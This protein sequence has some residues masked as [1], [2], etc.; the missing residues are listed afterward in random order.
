MPAWARTEIESPLVEAFGGISANLY[1]FG[2]GSGFPAH[3]DPYDV[4]VVT[5]YGE[6]TVSVENKTTV[7]DAG[8]YLVIEKGMS[9]VTRHEGYC[10]SMTIRLPEFPVE[11]CRYP[12]QGHLAQVLMGNTDGNN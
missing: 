8:G 10:I 12:E 11:G 5:L 6:K 1:Q 2:R 7:L 4:V 9:H 3:S